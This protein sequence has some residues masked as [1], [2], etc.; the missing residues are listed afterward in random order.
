MKTLYPLAQFGLSKPTLKAQARDAAFD[1][2]WLEGVAWPL[3]NQ[4][5]T[6]YTLEEIEELAAL[7]NADRD[8]AIVADSGFVYEFEGEAVVALKLAT[9]ERR[10]AKEREI[11]RAIARAKEA[12]R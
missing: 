4:R 7:M 5:T 12:V 3:L 1:D 11:D 8:R 2:E 6:R 9:H 10:I